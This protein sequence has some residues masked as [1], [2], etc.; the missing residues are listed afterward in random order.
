LII[1]LINHLSVIVLAAIRDSP[2]GEILDGK[3]FMLSGLRREI[4][5]R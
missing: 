3:N 1:V 4:S 5:Y 2:T